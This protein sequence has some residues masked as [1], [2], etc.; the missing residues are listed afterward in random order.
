MNP[1]TL[2]KR[3][4]TSGSSSRKGN[5]T[6]ETPTS[7]KMRNNFICTPMKGIYKGEIDDNWEDEFRPIS[8]L[9]EGAKL[10]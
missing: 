3:P 4:L 10:Y 8:I 6:I 7:Y 5:N 1:K 2:K 9:G